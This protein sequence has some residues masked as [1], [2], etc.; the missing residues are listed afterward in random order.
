M[1]TWF[2]ALAFALAACSPP[3]T[4]PRTGTIPD[5]D[6]SFAFDTLTILNDRGEELEFDIYLAMDYE[7][8]R[9]GLM[10]VLKMPEQTG[11]LFVYENEEARS[12]WMKNTFIPLDIVFA[13][14][15]GS[16]VNVVAD[17][18]PHTLSSHR[19]AGPA[20][21]VLELNAGTAERLGIGTGSRLLRED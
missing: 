9:R 15:D 17:T 16:V 4:A 19:S 13:R 2:L 1:R 3:A 12:M 11:M 7:Q 21:Y 8:Q 10:Y 14:A 6:A 5:L 18:V 20:R